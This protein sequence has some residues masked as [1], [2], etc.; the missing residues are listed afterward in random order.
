MATALV[1]SGSRQL[2]TNCEEHEF[3]EAVKTYQEL[4]LPDVPT[5]PTDVQVIEELLGVAP[6]HFKDAGFHMKA[7]PNSDCKGC[8]RQLNWL[9]VC[10]TALQTPGHTPEFILGTF[11]GEHG[12]VLAPPFRRLTCYGCNTVQDCAKERIVRGYNCKG[13]MCQGG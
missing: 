3:R 7:S 4:E 5:P 9:D 12:R 11:A 2:K 10:H 8:G 13:Y 1:Y 6:G